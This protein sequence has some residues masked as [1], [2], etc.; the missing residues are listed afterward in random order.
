MY[1]S[2]DKIVLVTDN[3]N[4]YCFVVLYEAFCVEEAHRLVNRFGW[5]FTPKHGG[6]VGYG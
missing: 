2:A 1:P 3:L 4:V 5:Y 6:L